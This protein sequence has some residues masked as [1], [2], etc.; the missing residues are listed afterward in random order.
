LGRF[1]RRIICGVPA[2]C[3]RPPRTDELV[4]EPSS[5]PTRFLPDLPADE[6]ALGP[7]RRI[8]D[9]VKHVVLHDP[10]GHV[11]GLTGSYGSGKSTVVTLLQASLA[12]QE[13][14]SV[15]VF[16]A[17][18]H[19]GDPLRRSFLES[20]INHFLVDSWV[21]EKKWKRR[22]EELT[23]RYRR[24]NT[25]NT[26]EITSFAIALAIALLLAPT[27]Y[28]LLREA[29]PN[30]RIWLPGRGFDGSATLGLLLSVSPVIVV[31]LAAIRG[32]LKHRKDSE[33]HPLHELGALLIQKSANR[34]RT[35]TSE[36]TDPTSIE[37]EQS[38]RDLMRDALAAPDRRAVL[39]VDNLDRVEPE[40]A[41]R[42]W[43]TLR[44]FL[45]PAADKHREEWLSRLWV[46][47]PYD[48]D[49]IRH[50]WEADTNGE[51]S[52]SGGRLATSFLDKTIDIRFHVPPP[53]L[54]NWRDYLITLLETALPDSLK[55]AELYRV[56]RL[57]ALAR[58]DTRQTPTPR[59]L[60]I[61]VNQISA[62]YRLRGDDIPLSDLAYFVILD[63]ET[64]DVAGK[65][66][67]GAVPRD[68]DRH[69]LSPAAAENLSALVFGVDREQGQQLLLGQPIMDALLE[70][71]G[72]ELQRLRT[73]TPA[74]GAVLE[75]VL[76]EAITDWVAPHSTETANLLTAATS[77]ADSGILDILD[78]HSQS[79][80]RHV[81]RTAATR[82]GIW[83]PLLSGASSGIVALN[84]LLR[85]PDVAARS[86]AALSERLA[87]DKD[88]ATI[89][90]TAVGQ[91]AVELGNGLHALGFSHAL[92]HGLVVPGGADAYLEAL[93]TVID[94]VREGND[95]DHAHLSILRPSDDSQAIVEAL[96]TRASSG[97]FSQSDFF[98][99]RQVAG[100]STAVQWQPLITAIAT[101]IGSG[102]ALSGPNEANMLL[103]AM[104]YLA[105]RDRSAAAR[106]GLLD[107]FSTGAAARA[108]TMVAGD[109]VD[110]HQARARLL[111]GQMLV[112]PS[113]QHQQ[114]GT[115]QTLLKKELSTPT[116]AVAACIAA[117]CE[118][119]DRRDL[120]LAT[121]AKSSEARPL[122]AEVLRRL[123][124]RG[125][126]SSFFSGSMIANHWHLLPDGFSLDALLSREPKRASAVA[127]H[128]E[129]GEASAS[130]EPLYRS[131]LRT[132]RHKKK[133]AAWLVKQ[134]QG[135]P[136]ADWLADLRGKEHWLKIAVELR[137]LGF[138][139]NLSQP[140]RAALLD[141]ATEL[142]EGS[143]RALLTESDALL[144]LM[145]PADRVIV[146][147]HLFSELLTSA[148]SLLKGFYKVFGPLLR[149]DPRLTS[150]QSVLSRVF[151]PLVEERHAPGVRWIRNL[152]AAK[153]TRLFGTADSE[154]V[155]AFRRAVAVELAEG[156]SD[157]VH[158]DA[159]FLAKRLQIRKARRS[160]GRS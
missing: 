95:P 113:F 157:Q 140:F 77:L 154:R 135:I 46:V 145:D 98:A 89:T 73:L 17:W 61:F 65:L 151:V 3:I 19:E 111:Y 26:Y 107:L 106:K 67:E 160:R 6:D 34:T 142:Q 90:P 25:E 56:Y 132:L 130:D 36:S 35:K 101:R 1:D 50:L 14:A 69:L 139:P 128:I 54:A 118:N 15:W 112:D 121:G 126:S 4:N 58:S 70:G 96:A 64:P 108:W 156:A 125:N 48:P 74:F 8:A 76:G 155:R 87:R 78:E 22:L 149:Q 10:G 109:K 24:T 97:L 103:A 131:V 49:G 37:F 41:Q 72:A 12:G 137:A 141:Y 144:E 45:D 21:G 147:D 92:A 83:N 5:R 123:Y 68:R 138:E 71:N 148:A 153:G 29:L 117:L 129:R 81:L 11:I 38:F 105:E 120:V 30:L 32:W 152:V 115:A 116:P 66:L 143:A 99:V 104:E 60:K 13:K 53:L 102:A 51:H 2:G 52:S 127:R 82:V 114:T 146:Q 134:I 62:M 88:E 59:E 158:E 47:I 110:H 9:T 133:F 85:D 31:A 39:V 43:S 18:A 93:A 40:D 75:H 79:H 27:G 23:H 150:D 7:H 63:R 42:I 122:V 33:R 119:A 94:A 124:E 80:I 44:T 86:V 100:D 84:Q 57:L 55:R 136:Q 20:L 159:K 91:M 16:D 28:A